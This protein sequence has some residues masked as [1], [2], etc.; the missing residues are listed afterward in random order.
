[1]LAPQAR[2]PKVRSSES[3]LGMGD[4][5]SPPP[6]IPALEDTQGFLDQAI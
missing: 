6:I 2:G 5:D 4:Y 3:I 1:M